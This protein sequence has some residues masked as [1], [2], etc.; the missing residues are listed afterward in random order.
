MERTGKSAL[1]GWSRLRSQLGPHRPLILPAQAPQHAAQ[2]ALA[3]RL[4]PDRELQGQQILLNVR[5][6]QQEIHQLSQP[7]PRQSVVLGDVGVVAVDAG[8]DVGDDP[9]G[10]REAPRDGGRLAFGELALAADDPRRTS[11][12]SGPE[13]NR[14]G[15]LGPWVSV[16]MRKCGFLTGLRFPDVGRGA[17]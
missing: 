5:R 11:A 10:Q 14:L 2:G 7:S 6:K 17:S 12:L 15:V 13:G 16:A 9:V 1:R 8:L 4:S 3:D